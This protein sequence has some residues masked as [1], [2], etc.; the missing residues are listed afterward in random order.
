VKARA[1]RIACIGVRAAVD[2]NGG[3]FEVGIDDGHIQ[4]AGSIRRD[5]VDVRSMIE[6][7]LYRT[8]ISIPDGKQQRR[9]AG[10]GLRLH[11]RAGRD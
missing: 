7:N 8:D 6:Q 11:I 2:Q 10:P 9:Q 3:E 5:I 1:A 4:C